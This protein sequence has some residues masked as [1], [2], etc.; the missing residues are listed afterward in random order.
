LSG[1]NGSYTTGRSLSVRFRLYS[2]DPLAPTPNGYTNGGEVEDYYWLF[3]PTAVTI[4]SLKA[5]ASADTPLG[6]LLLVG[7]IYLAATSLRKIKPDL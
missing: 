5:S 2:G 7:L 3:S 6:V 1:N 4:T